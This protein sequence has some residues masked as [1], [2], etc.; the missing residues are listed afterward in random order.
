MPVVA[1][2]GPLLGFKMSKHKGD[3]EKEKKNIRIRK[4]SE[5]TCQNMTNTWLWVPAESQIR[6]AE[7][8]VLSTH[9]LG[10]CRLG[11]S[12]TDKE[13]GKTEIY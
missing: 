3:R 2:G 1:L 13:T 9:I 10:G 8:S 12:F 11:R 5:V 4:N 7:R 6:A